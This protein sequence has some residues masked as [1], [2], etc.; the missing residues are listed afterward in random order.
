[1]LTGAAKVAVV[2]GQA[3]ESCRWILCSAEESE[4]RVSLDE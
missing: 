3:R 1:M 4:I 2:L